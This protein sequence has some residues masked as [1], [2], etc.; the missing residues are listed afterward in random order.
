M[1]EQNTHNELEGLAGN[2][3]DSLLDLGWQYLRKQKPLEATQIAKM[4]SQQFPDHAEACFLM[5]RS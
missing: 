3:V 5:V 1:V 4:L 2:S